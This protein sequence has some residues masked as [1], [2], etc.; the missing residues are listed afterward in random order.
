M[1]ARLSVVIPHYGDPRLARQ[2]ISDLAAQ[3]RVP[4]EVLVVDDASPTP[5]GAAPDSPGLRVQVIR[6]DANGGFGSAVNAGAEAARGNVLLVLNSDVRLKRDFIE[7]MLELH[8]AHPGALIAPAIVGTDGA[9]HDTCY[10]FFTLASQV[11]EAVRPIRLL[12]PRVGAPAGMGVRSVSPDS[13]ETPD[14]IGGVVLMLPL[15]LFR[16]VGGF[17]DG[18]YMYSEETDLQRRLA[19][20][21]VERRYEP[22]VRVEH[23]GGGSTDIW[24]REAWH[25][26]ARFVYARRWG[27]PHLLLLA[28]QPV[29]LHNVLSDCIAKA[30]GTDIDVRGRAKGLL[31]HSWGGYLRTRGVRRL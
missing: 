23:L 14:W 11:R 25:W 10:P 26:H 24:K 21:D 12:R 9:V 18:Y 31:R 3:S 28:L 29:V 7:R 17:Y 5:F 6:R 8:A 13:A 27:H 30:R 19:D 16:D 22:D 20:L 15:A 4:D 2:V 1:G